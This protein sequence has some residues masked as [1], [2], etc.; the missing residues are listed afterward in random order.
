M[1]ACMH[2]KELVVR[3]ESNMFKILPKILSTNFLTTLISECSIRVFHLKLTAL[4]EGIN[5]LSR[6]YFKT[7]NLCIKLVLMSLY[8]YASD[9]GLV[10]VYSVVLCAN[11]W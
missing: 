3:P 2:E 9:A 10:R 7:F 1:H 5:L 11:T 4:L 6:N 8:V